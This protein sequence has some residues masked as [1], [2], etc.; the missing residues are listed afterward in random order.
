LKPSQES[1][2]ETE[3]LRIAVVGDNFI[4]LISAAATSLQECNKKACIARNNPFSSGA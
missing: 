3:P 4:A 2:P 1:R